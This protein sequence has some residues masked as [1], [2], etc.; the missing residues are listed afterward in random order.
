MARMI[1][2][3]DMQPAFTCIASEVISARTCSEL[4]IVARY[5]LASRN[6]LVLYR[7]FEHGS[8]L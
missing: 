4:V 8:A 1:A 7:G 2:P 5:S 6:L 3:V